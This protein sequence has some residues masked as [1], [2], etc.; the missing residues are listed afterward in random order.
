M[1][2]SDLE[3]GALIRWLARQ[4]LAAR[5]TR[6]GDLKLF[7][8]RQRRSRLTGEPRVECPDCGAVGWHS[9]D[10]ESRGART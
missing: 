4:R 6:T 7:P 3:F 5:L 9:E 1:R 10:C 2:Q 8:R